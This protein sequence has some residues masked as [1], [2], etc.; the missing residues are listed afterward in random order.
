MTKFLHATFASAAAL[1]L[2][3]CGSSQDA[4]QEATADTVEM[5]AEEAMTDITGMP[6]DTPTDIGTDMAMPS[7]T[8]S[9]AAASATP[10]STKKP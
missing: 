8:M 7:D 4:S 5:P 9:D 10:G 6:S 2:A 3:G 1:A